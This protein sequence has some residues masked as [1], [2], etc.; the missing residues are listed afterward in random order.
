MKRDDCLRLKGEMTLFKEGTR[1]ETK[2]KG[3]DNL[4]TL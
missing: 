4:I 2:V 1:N 3:K